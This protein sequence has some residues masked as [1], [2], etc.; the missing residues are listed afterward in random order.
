MQ[1][2]LFDRQPVYYAGRFALFFALLA[3]SAA[4]VIFL[5]P[6]WLQFLCV[7][8]LTAALLQAS[9][10]SHDLGHRQVFKTARANDR[11]LLLLSLFIGASRGWWIDTHNKHHE[12]PNDPELDPNLRVPFLAFSRE[13]AAHYS[14]L[15]RTTMRLQGFY[16][17]GIVTLEALAMKI[18]SLRFLL[19]TPNTPYRLPEIA[20]IFLHVAVYAALVVAAGMS[21]WQVALF[22]TVQH[23][24]HGLYIGLVFAPNHKGMPLLQEASAD[25]FLTQQVETTR[26]VRDFFLANTLVG[27]LHFQIEHHLFT[28]L[29]R[30][31]LAEAR[32][33]VKPYCDAR[34]IRYV[35]TGLF[36][37]YA[38]VTRSFTEV[39]R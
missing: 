27:G 24:L 29:P 11:A 13:Q 39:A 14:G 20:L 1:A 30:N 19:R 22:A 26:N 10:L 35:E 17:W 31:R 33:L 9:F 6:F 15:V 32:K 18:H 28:N 37:S 3:A 34:E 8:P 7:L 5:R 25:D 38:Q 4:G 2:A 12:H 16:F 23:A 36:E 21:W